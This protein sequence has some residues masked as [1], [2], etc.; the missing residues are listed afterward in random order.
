[1]K[2]KYIVFFKKEIIFLLLLLIVV[3]ISFGITYANFVYNSNDKRAV[4][5]FAGSLNYN[6]KINGEYQ[7][8]I[9]V[10][11]GSSIINL[12]IKSTNEVSSFYKLLTNSDIVIYT[13]EGNAS[14]VIGSN[15]IVNIKLYIVNNKED[16]VNVPFIVSMGYLTNS[17]DDVKVVENYHEIQNIKHEIEY[18][19]K[20]WIIGRINDDASIDLISKNLYNIKLSGY[21]AYNDLNSLL[22]SKCITNGSKSID[23]NDINGISLMTYNDYTTINRLSY[24]PSIIKNI[25]DVI[26]ENDYISE[27]GYSYSNSILIRN[28]KINNNM[29]DTYKNGKF[30]LNNLYYEVDNNEIF[31]YVIEL[32]N[33]KVNL[34]KLYD[35]NNS[36]YEISSNVRCILNIKD[37]VF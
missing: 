37:S 7:N 10:S 20:T 23:I 34:R 21:D 16:I 22:N 13:I 11:K 9:E 33:G 32:D 27:S 18:D 25:E 15:D 1:M 5:M 4:E 12:E 30:L 28:K 17:L 35:S 24:F 29:D 3:C 2:D 19:N 14:G 31:Y 6:L 26:I 36:N 8:S